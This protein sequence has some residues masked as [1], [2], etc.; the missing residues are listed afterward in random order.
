MMDYKKPILK[1][2]P[3]EFNQVVDQRGYA[4]GSQTKD[5]FGVLPKKKMM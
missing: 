1:R 2:N 5:A 4:T 3:S